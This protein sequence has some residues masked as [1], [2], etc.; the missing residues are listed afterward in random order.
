MRLRVPE[1]NT[2]RAHYPKADA[3]I[4]CRAS[5][6]IA[7]KAHGDVDVHNQARLCREVQ[8]ELRLLHQNFMQPNKA[9]TLLL[10]D[11]MLHPPTPQHSCRMPDH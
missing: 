4:R 2:I 11:L 10:Q 8:H 1:T 3:A 5:Q 6:W 7:P 9:I